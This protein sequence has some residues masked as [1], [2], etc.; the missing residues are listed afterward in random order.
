[1]L[2]ADVD[3]LGQT[4]VA[5]FEKSKKTL[6]RMAT[7][8][9]QMSLFFKFHINQ[10]LNQGSSSLLSEA[11]PRKVTIVYSGGDDLFL[12]GAWNEVIACAID[13]HKALEQYAI[14][15]LHIS[16]G[17]GVFPAKYPLSV[18]A[19]EVEELEQKAKDYPGKN[20]IC[21][22]EEG[23]TY[24]WSTFIHSVIQEKLQTLTDFFDNQGERGMAF[25]YRLLDLIRDREEKINLARFAYVLARLEPKEK[26]K[27]ESYR[28]FSKKMY[29]WSNNEKDSKQLITAIYVYV[30]LN[31]KEDKN[32]D[33]K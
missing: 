24:D 19:R 30:Y 5:G 23:S 4:F 22:F 28:E 12:V 17:I 6:S 31:R 1:M 33:T 13:I 14:G 26:E 21:L 15:A 8:S 2:R 10:I 3:D 18:C 29:Q 32:Y 7:L 27:K 9:R 16:A 25:L 11:G 20:A